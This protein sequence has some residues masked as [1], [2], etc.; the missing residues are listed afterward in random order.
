MPARQLSVSLADAVVGCGG[1]PFW[2]LGGGA[3]GATVVPLLLINLMPPS[4]LLSLAEPAPLFKLFM[5]LTIFACTHTHK[6][7]HIIIESFSFLSI[8]I[9]S[10]LL[11]SVDL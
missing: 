6:L 1:V 5:L 9:F 7:I 8:I 4:P 3:S 11:F 2:A 10:F